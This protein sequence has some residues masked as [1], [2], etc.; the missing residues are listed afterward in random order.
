ML[1][2]M[3]AEQEDNDDAL[4]QQGA[5]ELETLNDVTFNSYGDRA[6]TGRDVH[7]ASAICGRSMCARPRAEKP[8]QP[9][10]TMA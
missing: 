7:G 2:S 10:L 6:V 3:G 4:R 9:R 5:A 1:A 8:A